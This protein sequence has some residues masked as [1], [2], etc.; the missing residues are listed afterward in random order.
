M[1]RL[2]LLLVLLASTPGRAADF[3]VKVIGV[4]DGDTLTVLRT[5]KTQV[6]IRLHDIDAPETGQDFATGRN[7]SPRCWPSTGRS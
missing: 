2:A 4:S 3:P 6:K 7:T 1:R 5:D